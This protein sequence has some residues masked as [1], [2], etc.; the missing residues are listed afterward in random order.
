MR[1][2]LEICKLHNIV[3]IGEEL[4]AV[5]G[6]YSN[7]FG[8]PTIHININRTQTEKSIIIKHLLTEGFLIDPFK[9]KFVRCE[10]IEHIL[11][12]EKAL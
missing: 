7:W 2:M 5:C 1:D 4:G 3:I 9:M 11:N 6:F 8:Q 10:Q 12:S